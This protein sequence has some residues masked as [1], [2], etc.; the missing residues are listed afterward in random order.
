MH[1][2]APRRARKRRR[3]RRR[4]ATSRAPRSSSVRGGH[5]VRGIEV[6][7]ASGKTERFACDLVAVSGG[8]N[9]TVHLTTHLNGKP[10]WSDALSALVPGTLPPGMSVAGA[11][12]GSFGL[13]ACLAEGHAAGLAAAA[14]CGFT[15]Q[16]RGAPA[17]ADEAGVTPSPLWQVANSR[18]KAFVDF[19]NDVTVSD[20][21]LAAREGFRIPEHLKRYTTL[22][23]ATDQGK[24]SNANGAAVLANVTGRYVGAVG[25]TT[26]RPPYHPDR[27]QRLRRASSR[28]GFPPRA[29]RPLACLGGGAGRRVRRD[30]PVA[31]RALL[32]QAGR[33]AAR[34][35]E[36][37]G[38]EC[39]QGRRRVRRLDARQDR[40]AGEGRRHLPRPRL[41]QH[42]LD[43]AGRQG[44]LWADAA[45][46]RL[47][48][49][50]RHHRAARRGPLFHDHHHRQCGQ[51][52]AASRIRPAMSLARARCRAGL[53]HRAMG[54]ICGGGAARARRAASGGRSGLRSFQ[55]GVSLSRL[56]RCHGLRRHAGP[57]V[58]PLVL[59]RAGLRGRRAGALRRQPGAR[60]HAGGGGLRHRALRHRGARR[61]AHRE[62]PSRRRRAERADHGARSRFRQDAVGQEGFHRPLHGGAAGADRSRAAD[63]WWDSGRSTGASGSAP[64]RI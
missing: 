52:H 41:C 42:L 45:R 23:M 9:P 17:V 25:T 30:R 62:G 56:R 57:A 64:A 40:R 55:R 53:G 54:A 15:A 31:A 47:R 21:K 44:A 38:G 3:R 59:R 2:R 18:G 24:T 35:G 51:G 12:S 28:P 34:R 27:H 14:E 29:A 22:G 4:P 26:F 13:G 33:G 46:G 32:P 36:P 16:A 37:R 48:A 1:E 63:R 10:Q 11:A 6:G 43:A 61:V 60:H 58:S 49:R 7:D 5:G 19:Q 8:W 50:R 39:P 20:V